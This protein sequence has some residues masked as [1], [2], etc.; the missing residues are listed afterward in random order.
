MG[1]EKSGGGYIETTT[2]NE[3]N[4]SKLKKDIFALAPGLLKIVC[5]DA[6]SN[7]GEA[8]PMCFVLFFSFAFK[9]W[10]RRLEKSSRLIRR[11][12]IYMNYNSN[13]AE[14]IVLMPGELNNPTKKVAEN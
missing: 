7:A 5:S 6:L 3:R 14:L 4:E 9:S 11:C 8:W 2:K 13:S 12:Q 1:K 10:H